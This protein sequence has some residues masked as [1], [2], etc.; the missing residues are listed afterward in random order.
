MTLEMTRE[1]FTQ[2]V[3][4]RAKRS[5]FTR[6]LYDTLDEYQAAERQT[7]GIVVACGRGCSWC[8]HQIVC[9]FPEEM[10]EITDHINRLASPVRVRL[11]EQAREILAKWSAWLKLHLP[12]A[13]K[14]VH[15]PLLLAQ[16]WIG[17]PCPLLQQ[18]GSCGVHEARPL[19]CR[20]TTSDMKC[21]DIPYRDERRHARQMRLK[22]EGWANNL[23]M[24]RAERQGVQGVTPLHYFLS[25]KPHKL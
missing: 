18:D 16:A 22:C 10:Q 4:E 25:T 12:F 2:A 19:V 6:A 1:A 3:E 13:P 15:N 21:G 9:V 17:K 8:C 7:T 11:R 24:E 5:G 20:T 23:Q 14:K